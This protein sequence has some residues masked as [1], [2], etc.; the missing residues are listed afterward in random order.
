ML[1]KT[2]AHY[3]ITAKLG[4]GGMG[5][6]WRARDTKLGREV[7]LKFLPETVATD[8]ARHARFHT[9]AQAL[10]SFA[11]PHVG[12][13]H[14][15]EEADGQHFLALELIEGVDLTDRLRQGPLPVKTALE[16]ASQIALALEAAHAKNI[17]HR[18]LKPANIKINDRD[19]I[20]I[21]DFGLA[22][23]FGEGSDES[24]TSAEFMPTVTSELTIAGAVLGTAAYMSPEQ[25]RGQS[26]DK[27]IDIWAVGCVLY[28]MLTGKLAF[29]GDTPSDTLAAVLRAEP[30]WSALPNEVTPATRRLLQRCLQK[31]ARQRLHDVADVR[32][33]L[34]DILSGNEPT[35]TAVATA[36]GSGRWR[37][38]ALVLTVICLVLAGVAGKMMSHKAPAPE[39]VSQRVLT[40]SGRDW[41]PTA[42]PDGRN[43]AFVSDRDGVPRIW[44]K[45]LSTGSEAP[46]TTGRDDLPRYSPDGSQILFVRN[47]DS[48]ESGLYRV[49]VVGGRERKVMSDVVEADWSPDGS[50]VAFLRAQSPDDD[51]EAVIGI[52][53]V[54]TGTER[55]LTT[56]KNRLMFSLRWSP[57]NRHIAISATA[58]TGNMVN[59]NSFSLIDPV[60]GEVTS[61]RIRDW[62]GSN[63]GAAWAPDGRSLVIGQSPDLLDY[64]SG[65]PS[66]IMQY[67]VATGQTR[68]LFWGQFRLPRGGWG[69]S[70]VAVLNDHQL[71]FDNYSQY[72]E[73]QLI[74]LS[75]GKPVGPAVPL[76]TS[77]GRDRQP[78]FSRDGNRVVFSSNRS[79]NIDLWSVDLVSGR[80]QQLT[81]DPAHDWD[82]AFSPDG[83]HVIWSSSRSGNME[84]WLANTDG[85][86]ARQISRDGEDAENPTMTADGQWIIYASS[87]DAKVGVWKIRPDG[88]D[89]QLLAPGANLLPEVSPTRDVALYST[90]AGQDFVVSVLDLATGK[91][92]DFEIAIHTFAQGD[93]LVFGR[94]RWSAD[95]RSIVFVGLDEAG[96]SGIFSQ[97]F[98]PGR[99][100]SD[101]RIRL[102]EPSTFHSMESMGL[103]PDGSY[104]VVSAMFNRRSLVMAEKFKLTGWD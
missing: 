36:T 33:E 43:V 48:G 29:V 67:D 56:F 31:D 99:D 89:A 40:F 70:T 72:A 101:E 3:E 69:F 7:A 57:D 1:G 92:L 38:L 90:I 62:N 58:L 42:S 82:P 61:T 85:T 25:A 32:I 84:I 45:Q 104:L 24:S 54:Q 14:A 39:P 13:V 8:P 26:I 34:D 59:I 73:L 102:T 28:E 97:P 66:L 44:L 93:D 83:Q 17:I 30:D 76:T 10:A 18:D 19:Q 9:E 37:P 74:P 78:V 88:S 86:G 11:H 50:E 16:I 41:A 35:P 6:V 87:N 77:L 22:K 64:V 46:L 98:V 27:R 4:E 51:T 95:G 80:L 63:T 68:D 20:K 79:G 52:A 65:F 47:D 60:S 55:I 12:G 81:D 23:F 2:I 21:L 53:D 94:S 75:D 5:V 49:A 100:T 71:V 96:A 15:L 103:S 91:P